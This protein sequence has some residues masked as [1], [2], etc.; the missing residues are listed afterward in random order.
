MTEIEALMVIAVRLGYSRDRGA[1]WTRRFPVSSLAS[2]HLMGHWQPLTHHSTL[3][4][5]PRGD[6]HTKATISPVVTLEE[7]SPQVLFLQSHC[8]KQ[9][10]L[11][12][13]ISPPSSICP[14][15]PVLH[16]ECLV[17]VSLILSS[18]SDFNFCN[19]TYVCLRSNYY[20]KS[21]LLF[22]FSVALFSYWC[23]WDLFAL[24]P[25]TTS[26]LQTGQQPPSIIPS[27]DIAKA[28]SRS[29]GAKKIS[30]LT[31]FSS[32]MEEKFYLQNSPSV[33]AVRT[34]SCILY[35]SLT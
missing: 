30:L 1:W 25:L 35:W 27:Q 10:C 12:C 31:F 7:I 8:G 3:K 28:R 26:W 11:F 18:F 14:L 6:S 24:P 29:T 5:R 34:V 2:C 33:S 32:F 15:T 17:P 21:L 9:L 22:I 16:M 13:W 23:T 20:N 4:W 19:P